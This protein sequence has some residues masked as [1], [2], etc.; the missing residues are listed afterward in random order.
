[1]DFSSVRFKPGDTYP[2]VTNYG[3]AG[4]ESVTCKE[5]ISSMAALIVYNDGTCETQNTER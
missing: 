4:H 3:K 2:T 5:Y 1:M